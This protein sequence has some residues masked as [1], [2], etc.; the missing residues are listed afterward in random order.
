MTVPSS[1]DSHMRDKSLIPQ[2]AR[3][4]IIGAGA[5]GL[6]A[7]RQL[8]LAGY[9]PQVYEATDHIGGVWAYSPQPGSSSPMYD[10][11]HCN[12]PKY[13]MTFEQIPYPPHVP[14]FPSHRQV[15]DYIHEYAHRHDLWPLISFNN[16]VKSASKRDG[17][18]HI[19]TDRDTRQY[20][21]LYVCSGHFSKPRDWH[22][23]G[24]EHLR[25]HGTL[26]HHSLMY[27]KPDTYQ[28]Q[29][30]L[31]IGAGPSGIDIALELSTVAKHVYLS[32]SH[33]STVIPINAPENLSEIGLITHVSKDG[34][35]HHD[36]NV[37]DAF[38]VN[39]VLLCNGYIKSFPFLDLYPGKGSI[40]GTH[41]WPDGR[42]VRGL[43]RHCV[44]RED[45]T[46]TFVGLPDKM[47]PFPT[48][49]QQIAFSVRVL[50]GKVSQ[51]QLKQLATE[52]DAA[53]VDDKF[54]QVLGKSQWEYIN[55]MSRLAGRPA[56]NPA[57]IELTVDSGKR[58][59]SNPAGYRNT[60]Y[61]L[62]GEKEG[63]WTV[64]PSP[65]P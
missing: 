22:V 49:E 16:P 30:V 19:H 51:K 11:L 40:A 10:S 65:E 18:W 4:A 62:I 5:A 48:F 60:Q 9:H 26:I 55:E 1:D 53:N 33:D 12:L 27:K 17:M 3:I 54:Y 50:T 52:E 23:D 58:R 45:P 35:V 32:H 2:S 44:A 14:S 29:R 24:M 21:A 63:M 15:L 43:V 56:T 8:R 31:V 64:T 47:I 13:C 38:R 57:L 34:L 25:S 41:I 39:V 42:S 28:D 61:K 6:Q 59:R 7:A 36:K 20:H 46:L 37:H